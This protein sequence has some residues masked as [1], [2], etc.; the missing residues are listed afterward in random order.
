MILAINFY[1]LINFTD[2]VL[3]KLVNPF[4]WYWPVERSL[5]GNTTLLSPAVTV[6]VILFAILTI[7]AVTIHSTFSGFGEV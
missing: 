7:I 3:P 5:V 4:T 1:C 2:A 6:V